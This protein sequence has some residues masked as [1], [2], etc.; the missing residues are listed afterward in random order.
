MKSYKKMLLAAA[1]AIMLGAAPALADLKMGVAAEPYAPFTSKDASGVWVGWEVD[2]MNALC[3]EIGEIQ[4]SILQQLSASGITTA[5][6][7][8]FIRA[9][10]LIDAQLVPCLR[11]HNLTADQFVYSSKYYP[12]STGSLKTALPRLS[13]L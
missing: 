1:A 11:K 13:K 7:V 9:K 2:F 10:S 12:S 6:A 8:D 3:A 5:S 4:S